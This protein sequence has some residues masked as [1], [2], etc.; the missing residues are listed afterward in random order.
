MTIVF[1]CPNCETQ[2]RAP[3]EAAGR[4]AKCTKCEA[5][6]KIPSG[7]AD[8]PAA[9]EE[10]AAE[11]SPWHVHREDGQDYGPI[12]KAE[13]DL[14]VQQGRLDANSQVIQEGWENWKW[15][16]EVYPQLA[17]TGATSGADEAPISTGAADAG[18]PFASPLSSGTAMGPEDASSLSISPAMRQAMSQTRPWV[19]FFAILGFLI[20]GLMALLAIL[21]PLFGIMSGEGPI[22]GLVMALFYALMAAMHL[23]PAWFLLKY[24][25]RI[26]GFL[27]TSA[28]LDLERALLAQKSFWKFTGILAAI[29]IGLYVLLLLFVVIVGAGAAIFG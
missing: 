14:W 24:F 28:V 8:Q 11:A 1:S 18:N 6:V 19:L 16:P 10:P 9:P 29:V 2:L 13:L 17:S 20:G 26:G 3:D 4:N 25:Q 7:N 12:S 5:V 23:V 27:R 21:M 15:A 22:T